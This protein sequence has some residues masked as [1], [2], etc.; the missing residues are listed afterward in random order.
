M[1]QTDYVETKFILAS[2]IVVCIVS[3]SWRF[4]FPTPGSARSELPFK[5]MSNKSLTVF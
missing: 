1:F 5:A 2:Q 3:V 4:H